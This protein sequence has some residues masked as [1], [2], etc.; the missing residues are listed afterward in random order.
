MYSNFLDFQGGYQKPP[1]P[2]AWDEIDTPWEIGL[3]NQNLQNDIYQA[4]CLKCKEPN[5]PNQMFLIKPT[6]LYPPKKFYKTYSR[7]T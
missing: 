7:Y 3:T 2:L 5:I 6:K 1:R 4:K